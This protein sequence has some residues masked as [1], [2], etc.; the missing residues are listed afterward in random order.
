VP[1]NDKDGKKTNF[2]GAM[3]TLILLLYLLYF[4]LKFFSWEYI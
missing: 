1:L 3:F 2:L 4:Y